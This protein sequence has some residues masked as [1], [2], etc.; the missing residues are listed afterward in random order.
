[1]LNTQQSKQAFI[2]H[3]FTQRE[4]EKEEAGLIPLSR[5]V[6]YSS[7]PTAGRNLNRDQ[8]RLDRRLSSFV[9]TVFHLSFQLLMR[10]FFHGNKLSDS[11]IY[12]ATGVSAF[13]ISLTMGHDHSPLFSS[14][15]CVCPV[16]S[17]PD[18]L[19]ISVILTVPSR[20]QL[21]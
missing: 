19:E 12:E 8:I 2:I 1:M 16:L 14:I 5:D 6:L 17:C 7:L 15:R 4:R 20:W 21:I 9:S 3:V 11:Y 13:I 10:F 18:V